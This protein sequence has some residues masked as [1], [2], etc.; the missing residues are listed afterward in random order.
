MHMDVFTLA[1][2]DVDACITNMAPTSHSNQTIDNTEPT[3]YSYTKCAVI[4]CI[5]HIEYSE[6]LSDKDY[7]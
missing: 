6:P 5:I 2:I 4:R 7:A 1:V 3:P